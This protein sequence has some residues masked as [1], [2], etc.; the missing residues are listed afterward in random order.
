MSAGAAWRMAAEDSGGLF[1]PD[2]A[3][4][5]GVATKGGGTRAFRVKNL[6]TGQSFHVK[7]APIFVDETKL[8]T[9]GPDPDEGDGGSVE[10]RKA[11]EQSTARWGGCGGHAMVANSLIASVVCGGHVAV[12]ATMPD[13]N[14]VL[15]R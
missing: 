1:A 6:D 3:I 9:F 5:W 4:A 2:D 14:P 11:D 8:T 7:N 10:G 13:L 15:R 12:S